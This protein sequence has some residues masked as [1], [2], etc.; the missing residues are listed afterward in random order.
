[1]RIIFVLSFILPL[2]AY[3]TEE[4]CLEMPE[5]ERVSSI[6]SRVLGPNSLQLTMNLEEDETAITSLLVCIRG[7]FK[8]WKIEKKM[9]ENKYDLKNIEPNTSITCQ[10]TVDF[11]SDGSDFEDLYFNVKYGKLF[12]K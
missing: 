5:S 6:C 8:V 7:S 12:S 11:S 2:L 10:L 3:R 9:H 1:M 4:S